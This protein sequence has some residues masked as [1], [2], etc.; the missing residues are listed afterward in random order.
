MLLDAP[1]QDQPKG[2][3]FKVID[4][5]YIN[6]LKQL[7][8]LYIQE[9]EYVWYHFGYKDKDADNILNE[10]KRIDLHINSKH[11]RR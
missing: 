7:V 2:Q 8:K 9:F 11:K 5:S 10:L 4:Q 1:T 3:I 6:K